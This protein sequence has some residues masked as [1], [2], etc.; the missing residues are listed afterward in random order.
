MSAVDVDAGPAPS[1]AP[2]AGAVAGA[3][4]ARRRLGGDRFRAAAV[5]LAWVDQGAPGPSWPGPAG[6]GSWWA[7][8]CSAEAARAVV[9]LADAGDADALRGLLRPDPGVGAVCW[10]VA[11]YRIGDLVPSSLRDHTDPAEAVRALVSCGDASHVAAELVACGPDGL[12]WV[13]LART[14][15][16]VRFQ[17]FGPRSLLDRRG[18]LPAGGAEPAAPA[19]AGARRAWAAQLAAWATV[20]GGAVGLP[21]AWRCPPPRPTDSGPV[22]A[23]ATSTAPAAPTVVGAGRVRDVRTR[24]PGEPARADV[25]PEAVP[26]WGAGPGPG[27]GR[28]GSGEG[29]WPGPGEGSWPGPDDLVGGPVPGGRAWGSA[30]GLTVS[31]AE[32]ADQVAA[33]TAVLGRLERASAAVAARLGAVEQAVAAAEAVAAV[34]PSAP[35]AWEARPRLVP[36]WARRRP[37]HK[38]RRR[39]GTGWAGPAVRGAAESW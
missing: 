39:A 35:G 11:C 36:A 33:M 30:D 28:P 18:P 31:V 29:S 6:D 8:D 37:Q 20:Q 27:G 32:L 13:A 22:W 2:P 25:A 3:R 16:D 7:A 19:V 9:D 21:W 15:E 17:P 1:G 24:P 4:L 34:A 26:G 12:A 10:T 5:R 23:F 38:R 14:G